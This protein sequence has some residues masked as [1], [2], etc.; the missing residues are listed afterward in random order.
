MMNFRKYTPISCV[1]LFFIPALH[2]YNGVLICLFNTV[3]LSQS[4]MIILFFLSYQIGALDG[5]G[6]Y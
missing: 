1:N 2:L 5:S 3:S 6:E 4:L